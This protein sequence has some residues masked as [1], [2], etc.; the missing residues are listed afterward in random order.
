MLDR[1]RCWSYDTGSSIRIERTTPVGRKDGIE[2]MII[3]SPAVTDRVHQHR[4]RTLRV[5][6]RSSE[7]APR[8]SLRVRIGHLLIAA[9]SSLSGDVVERPGRRSTMTR[10]V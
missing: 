2:P 3:P 9:G 6:S 1:V 4:Q 8:G 7:A 10:P 5:Q